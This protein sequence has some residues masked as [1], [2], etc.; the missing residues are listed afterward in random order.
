M[1]QFPVCV[2]ACGVSDN[3]GALPGALFVLAPAQE[4][5]GIKN[6]LDLDM[7]KAFFTRMNVEASR[8]GVCGR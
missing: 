7:F 8:S 4:F 6:M 5:A 1:C 3:D 2:C